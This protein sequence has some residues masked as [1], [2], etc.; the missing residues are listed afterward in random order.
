MASVIVMHQGLFGSRV[1][2][3]FCCLEPSASNASFPKPCFLLANELSQLNLG[4]P[5]QIRSLASRKFSSAVARAGEEDTWGSRYTCDDLENQRNSYNDPH[6]DLIHPVPES[7]AEISLKTK[8]WLC[9]TNFLHKLRAVHLHVLASEQWNASRLA[10]C[11]RYYVTSAANLIHYLAIKSLDI[12]LLQ[13]DPIG[14]L[15]LNLQAI[16]SHVLAS[17]TEGIQLYNY[18][19]LNSLKVHENS[20]VESDSI[21]S[22]DKQRNGDFAINA[23]RRRASFNRE[24]LFGTFHDRRP[25]HIMATVGV[26][27]TQSESLIPDLLNNGTTMFRINCAHGD[28]N[29]WYEIIRRVKHSSQVLEKP[30]RILMDLAGPKLRTGKFKAGPRVIKISPKRKFNGE[31]DNPA[32]VW[33]L[34]DGACPPPTRVPPD[35]VLLIDGPELI[36]RL[37]PGDVLRFHDARGKERVLRIKGRLHVTGGNGFLAECSRTAYVHSGAEFYLKQKKGKHLVGRVVEVPASEP[38]IRLRVGDLLIISRDGLSEAGPINGAHRITCPSGYLFDSVKPGEPIYFDDGRIQGVI[39]GTSSSEV[40]VSITHAGIRGTKLGSDK[41]INIPESNI[42]FQGLTSKDLADLEFVSSCADMMG[43]S[44]VRD[45]QDIILLRRELKQ[46][47]LENVGIILKIET[48]SGF[49]NLPLLLLEA[50][51]GPNPLGVMIARGDLAV[52]CGWEKLA[53]LQEEIL[54]ICGAAHVPVIWATQ[55]LESL[56][57]SGVPTR[58]E[59]TDVALGMRASCIMLNKGKNLVNAVSMLDATLRSKSE[60]TTADMVKPLVLS[61]R[62]F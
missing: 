47:K 30:C 24:R 35:A 4:S 25:A 11:H 46:R 62:L 61:S 51:K 37:G 59:I 52:E 44:F 1:A 33:L 29:L 31:V 32:Q 50:M 38:F 5:Q 18:T 54:S 28:S 36:V 45:V 57:K 13:D 34:Q 12:E 20:L 14:I 7:Q 58:A 60:K 49:E 41:S 9:E 3:K 26:E 10:L 56:I 15:L 27:A 42:W 48:R 8:Q 19:N 40:I 43:I 23:M 16:N 55:V 22:V 6:V 53:Y 21:E 2:E 39:Q 17:I